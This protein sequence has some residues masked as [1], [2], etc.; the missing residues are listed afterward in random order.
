MK[1]SNTKRVY[2][3]TVNSLFIVRA[4]KNQKYIS[5]ENGITEVRKIIS[6]GYFHENHLEGIRNLKFQLF[7]ISSWRDVPDFKMYEIETNILHIRI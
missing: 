6:N 4:A 5:L 3:Y 7:I 2:V 1:N